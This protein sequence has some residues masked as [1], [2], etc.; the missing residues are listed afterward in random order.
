MQHLKQAF[1]RAHLLGVGVGQGAV[2]IGKNAVEQGY[3]AGQGD[4]RLCR[5]CLE[6][7]AARLHQFLH[8]LK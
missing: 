4:G 6:A 7:I 1:Y 8:M 2:A 5:A 3:M